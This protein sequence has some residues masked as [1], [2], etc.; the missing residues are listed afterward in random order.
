M[1]DIMKRFGYD[2][3][4]RE[5]SDRAH[6]GFQE[7]YPDVL[8]WLA[9]R[10]RPAAPREVL[11]VPH[12]GIVPLARRVHW[13]EADTRQA[14]VR[15]RVTSATEIDITARWA[16]R[17]TLFLNDQLVDLDRPVTIRVNGLVAFDGRIQRSAR[18]ALEEA[19]SLKDERRVYSARVT[20]AV[21]DTPESTAVAYALSDE[22]APRH[23]EGTLSYWE[24]YAVRALE[25]RF[26]GIGFAASE[27]KLP[28]GVATAPEQVG[29]QVTGVDADQ[30]AATAGLM[31]GDVLVSFGG[32]L[33]F[34]GRD[35][36]EGLYH[37]LVRELRTTKAD[38][39]LVVLRAGRRVTLRALYG[40]GPYRPPKA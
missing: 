10:P 36:A 14:L 16:S 5:F 27:T 26:P 13:I 1:D 11:R 35:G 2:F 22:L 19:R 38:Y 12:R 40:L 18:V 33:F 32:E 24:M 6:E 17:L 4:Y 39:E 31:A 28:D 21:T 37:W 20:V 15:A 34:A 30:P 29:L 7:H 25:E 3:V 8:R 9:E 23:P